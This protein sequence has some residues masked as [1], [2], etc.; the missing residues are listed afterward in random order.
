[1]QSLSPAVISSPHTRVASLREGSGPSPSWKRVL[2][3]TLVW[4]MRRGR[5]PTT[6]G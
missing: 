6:E 2:P 1:M 3:P 5:L 4:L